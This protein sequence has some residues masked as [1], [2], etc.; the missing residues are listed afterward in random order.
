[1]V[2]VAVGLV[3]VTGLLLSLLFFFTGSGTRDLP[4]RANR[5]GSNTSEERRH[6]VSFFV[7]LAEENS[8]I[9]ISQSSN[10]SFYV[11]RL[12]LQGD[13]RN[14]SFQVGKKL[15]LAALKAGSRAFLLEKRLPLQ[16]YKGAVLRLSSVSG[17][18]SGE[19]L[20]VK[21]NRL[22]SYRAFASNITAYTFRVGVVRDD[23]ITQLVVFPSRIGGELG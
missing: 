7:S 8:V 13:S 9:S 10:A 22:S 19:P 17:R 21:D 3:L 6:N 16:R 14:H 2:L 15:S 20:R 12:I 5:S 11:E 23:D 18:V 1:M 4:D